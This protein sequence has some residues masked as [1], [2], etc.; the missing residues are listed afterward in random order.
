M[1]HTQL[2]SSLVEPLIHFPIF[3]VRRYFQRRRRV[4]APPFKSD[5]SFRYIEQ[6]P[7]KIYEIE[8][9]RD[10]EINNYV[11][12]LLVEKIPQN[13]LPSLESHRN[14]KWSTCAT[15][16]EVE[17]L[18]NLWSHRLERV[19]ERLNDLIEMIARDPDVERLNLESF[20]SIAQFFLEHRNLEPAIIADWDGI[21]AVEWRLAP[22]DPQGKDLTSGGILCL[23]FLPDGSIEY[24]GFKKD[25]ASGE[26]TIYEG[27]VGRG[28]IIDRIDSFLQRM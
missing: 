21:L 14:T 6:K 19:A 2:T 27:T 5:Y 18:T 10:S 16:V 23:D 15:E 11:L 24:S 4:L 8:I 7:T 26:D 9:V 13:I 12:E 1:A 25:P 28:E 3:R 22:I 20:K 17:I